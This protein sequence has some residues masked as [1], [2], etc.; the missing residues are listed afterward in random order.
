MRRKWILI[1]FETV[2]VIVAATLLAGG[3]IMLWVG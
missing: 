3:L 2:V 1:P